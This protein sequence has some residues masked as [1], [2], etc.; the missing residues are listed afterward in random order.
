M[1]TLPYQQALDRIRSEFIEMPGMRLTPAQVSRL[2]GVDRVVCKS[3]LE[4][5]DRAGFLCGSNG[6][7]IKRQHETVRVS[8]LGPRRSYLNR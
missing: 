5:L 3:V 6:S 2:A 7:Y 1:N 4:D 8:R